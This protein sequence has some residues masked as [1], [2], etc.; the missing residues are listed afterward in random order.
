MNVYMSLNVYMHCTHSEH[1][2]MHMYMSEQFGCFFIGKLLITSSAFI[3]DVT[4]SITFT[5]ILP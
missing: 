3:S 5:Y 2:Y 1:A 4:Y